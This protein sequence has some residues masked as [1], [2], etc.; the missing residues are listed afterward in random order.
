MRDQPLT[1]AEAASWLNCSEQDVQEHMRAGR[2]R[3]FRPDSDDGRLSLNA[4]VVLAESLPVERR[5][6]EVRESSARLDGPVSGPRSPHPG[7]SGGHDQRP[8]LIVERRPTRSF[9]P[10]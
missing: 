7:R 9:T 10:R 1:I 5:V 4:V 6:F 2:L 3:P 8:A